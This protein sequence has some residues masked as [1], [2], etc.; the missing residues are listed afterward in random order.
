MKSIH[1]WVGSAYDCLALK[2]QQTGF[3]Q[4]KDDHAN[5]AFCLSS[6]KMEMRDSP[7]AGS[8]FQKQEPLATPPLPHVPPAHLPYPHSAFILAQPSYD[9]RRM[10]CRVNSVGLSMYPYTFSVSVQCSMTTR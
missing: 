4:G 7:R 8:G 1:G 6:C 9:K 2:K 5:N 10:P 3:L